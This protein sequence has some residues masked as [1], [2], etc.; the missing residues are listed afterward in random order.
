MLMRNHT[1]VL[2]SEIA[3]MSFMVLLLREHCL[4]N[5]TILRREQVMFLA[6]PLR[7]W[8]TSNKEIGAKR[9]SQSSGSIGWF[10]WYS[11]AEDSKVG[12]VI[13]SSIL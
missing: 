1:V 8:L 5:T 4:M 12:S 9:P 7:Y 2:N 6:S 3:G 10:S 11:I 13:V